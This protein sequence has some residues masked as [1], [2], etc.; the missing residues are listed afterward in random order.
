MIDVMVTVDARPAPL[1]LDPQQTALLVIDLQNDFGSPGG[2]FDR[3]GLD[4]SGIAAAAEA[5]KP[6]VESARDAGVPVIWVKM[7]H[8]PDL[9][10]AG[11]VGSPHRI[12]H[13]DFGDGRTLIRGTWNTDLLDGLSVAAGDHVVA[14]HRYSAFFE[15]ELDE[16]LRSLGV[17]T[18]IV[19]GCTTS[20]C[21][22]ST[23][24]DAMFRDY[25]CLVLEDCTAEPL[26]THESSL[27][28]IEALF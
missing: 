11:P 28:V 18:L 12:K 15:T 26:G 2:M 14:K 7:G 4:L 20:I 6:V 9:S 3:K 1:E 10:D 21:V 5:T 16:L 8:A 19:T 27:K 24:R 17:R 23:V 22:E 13:P 25:A